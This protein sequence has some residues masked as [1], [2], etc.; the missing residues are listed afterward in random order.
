MGCVSVRSHGMCICSITWDVYLFDHMGRVS[1]RSHGT[2]ICSI[3]WDV[4][5]FDHMGCVSVRSYGTCIC[6]IIWDVYLF[7]PGFRYGQI[8]VELTKGKKRQNFKVSVTDKQHQKKIF[9]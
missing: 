3:I 1:V 2:C 7:D 8:C 9:T 5:L 6:S 4:Y